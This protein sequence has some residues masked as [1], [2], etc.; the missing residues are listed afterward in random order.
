MA[1]PMQL[2]MRSGR[3][4]GLLSLG[5]G[6]ILWSLSSD[7]FLQS[8]PKFTYVHLSGSAPV[9]WVLNVL[10]LSWYLS[11]PGCW[12]FLSVFLSVSFFLSTYF[13]YRSMDQTTCPSISFF[14][15]VPCQWLS[16]N[17][18]ISSCSEGREWGVGSVVVGSA[19]GAPQ[20]FAPNCSE[21]LQNKG[22]G[23]SELKIGAPPKRRFNDHRSNAPF[24]ALW[25]ALIG[26]F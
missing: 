20:I 13:F 22:F 15:I 24:S 21:S 25:L 14:P 9:R 12:L 17:H 6:R 2:T 1:A 11:M 16:L 7:D 4:S 3:K 18:F 5:F 10:V 26:Y 8:G 23:V 19:L